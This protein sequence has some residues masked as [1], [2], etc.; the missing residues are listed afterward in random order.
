MIFLENKEIF[1][2]IYNK[3]TLH[4]FICMYRQKQIF[5][6]LEY[7]NNNKNNNNNNNK[8]AFSIIFIVFYW[9]LWKALSKKSMKR[10]NFPMPAHVAVP[11]VKICI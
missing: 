7:N 1:I 8:K 11:H 3:T 9:R 2:K 4:M 10:I 5:Y 6:I